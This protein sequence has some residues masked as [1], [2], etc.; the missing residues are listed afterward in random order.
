MCSPSAPPKVGTKDP[1]VVPGASKP[2]DSNSPFSQPYSAT[3]QWGVSPTATN[4]DAAGRPIGGPGA[5][6]PMHDFGTDYSQPTKPPG[7]SAIAT[8]PGT[9]PNPVNPTGIPH[10]VSNPTG[11][12]NPAGTTAAFNS[13]AQYVG[14]RP[15]AEIQQDW[16]GGPMPLPTTPTPTVPTGGG[17]GGAAPS[18]GGGSTSYY[19]AGQQVPQVT[20]PTFMPKVSAPVNPQASVAQAMMRRFRPDGWY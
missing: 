2:I 15:T 4:V 19:V 8:K 12:P 18:G 10:P 9:T 6:D 13:G 11:I 7:G 1:S 14:E 3:N 17:D 20:S 5:F 16:H